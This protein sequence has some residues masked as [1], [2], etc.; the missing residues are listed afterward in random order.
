MSELPPASKQK[1]S[2]FHCRLPTGHAATLRLRLGGPPARSAAFGVPALHLGSGASSSVVSVGGGSRPGAGL[3]SSSV[4]RAAMRMEMGKTFER[5]FA[6]PVQ[7]YL[8]SSPTYKS[9]GPL[10]DLDGV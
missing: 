8:R 5:G 6:P 9:N 10:D 7:E 3:Q 2:L 4:T 1:S